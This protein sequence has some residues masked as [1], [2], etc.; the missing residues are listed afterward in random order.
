[1]GLEVVGSLDPRASLSVREREVYEQVCL[2]LS[3]REIAAKLFIS[4][5]TVKVHLHHV[6]DKTGVRSRTALAMN[7]VHERFRQATS[8]TGPGDSTSSLS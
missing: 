5:A 2:G 8:E 7:A 1:M 6:Y 4:E 3:N